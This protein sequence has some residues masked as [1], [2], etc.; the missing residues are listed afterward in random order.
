MKY[1][2]PKLLLDK[3]HVSIND[4]VCPVHKLPAIVKM[5]SESGKLEINTC[6]KEFNKII[7]NICDHVKIEFYKDQHKNLRR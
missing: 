2:H 5:D 3:I 4:N 6:C 7:Q 1:K